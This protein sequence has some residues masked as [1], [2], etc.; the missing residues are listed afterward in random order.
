M[1]AYVIKRKDNGYYVQNNRCDG[2]DN[3]LFVGGLFNATFYYTIVDAQMFIN[4][5]M[6]EGCEIIKVELNEDVKKDNLRMTE[7]E[8]IK[9][10]HTE[11]F[12]KFEP[13]Y[14]L[15]IEQSYQFISKKGCKMSIYR[16]SNNEYWVKYVGTHTSFDTY[17]DAVA[18]AKKRFLGIG[19][20]EI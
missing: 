18:D 5:R 17:E 10:Y 20:Y 13:P 15:D 4:K 2:L 14:S 6:L 11:R 16:Y 8:F 1:I 7:E 12:D 19:E 9:N 3:L